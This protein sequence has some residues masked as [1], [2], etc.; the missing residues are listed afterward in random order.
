M[1]CD[2]L[3]I[4]ALRCRKPKGQYDQTL[5]HAVPARA[6]A[7]P[8]AEGSGA[9]QERRDDFIGRRQLNKAS[10]V[11]VV[12]QGIVPRSWARQCRRCRSSHRRRRKPGARDPATTC[13]RATDL[14]V[15]ARTSPAS[16]AATRHRATRNRLFQRDQ[17]LAT[18]SSL[19]A[20]RA[21]LLRFL[22]PTPRR[23]CARLH[24]GVQAQPDLVRALHSR[25]T[26]GIG[27]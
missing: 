15:A 9:A 18:Y 16:F 7:R 4:A 19:N 8:A 3:N 5:R 23:H 20:A 25:H 1:G 13:N 27:A 26:A 12:E 22:R 21:A 14:A 24:I 2:S 17:V 11:M 6:C 10:S